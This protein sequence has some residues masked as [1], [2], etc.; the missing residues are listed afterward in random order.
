MIEGRENDENCEIEVPLLDNYRVTCFILADSGPQQFSISFRT[1]SFLDTNW[2]KYQ[3][4][5]CAD[6][7]THFLL[8]IR[9]LFAILVFLK[10]FMVKVS[11]SD[12]IEVCSPLFCLYFWRKYAYFQLLTTLELFFIKN[13]NYLYRLGTYK[14]KNQISQESSE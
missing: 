6:E 1:S 8:H 3:K 7:L 13:F 10:Y 11:E 12:S 4:S 5:T 9:T 2:R 14:R